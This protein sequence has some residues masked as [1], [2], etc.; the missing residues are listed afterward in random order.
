MKK[1]KFKLPLMVVFILIIILLVISLL[2]GYIW[3]VLTTSDFFTVKHVLVRNSSEAFEYL[4]GRNIFNLNLNNESAKALSNCS[5]CRKV[6]FL[7]ILPNYIIVDFLKRQPV[8]LVKFYKN[9]A[10]DQQGVF[11]NPAGS[12]EEADLPI[13]YGLETK[14]FGPKP[15]VKYKRPE[16]D[17][18]L[19]VIQEFRVNRALRVFTLKRI[20]VVSLQRASLFVLLPKQA[21]DYA[22]P[23]P[24]VRWLGFEVRIGV[25][26]IKQKLMILGGLLMQADKEWANIRYIDLRFKEPVIKLNN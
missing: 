11:F 25:G 5:N 8:A 22:K 7:R 18:A 16:I 10:I 6:R 1:Q 24:Q 3:K 2:L 14:I 19:S 15:G 13:I 17:L 23:I 26:N 12:A 21:V 20:D 9:Y 4:K